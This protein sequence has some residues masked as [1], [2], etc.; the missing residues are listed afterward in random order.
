M[1]GGKLMVRDEWMEWQRKLNKWN[2]GDHARSGG[3]VQEKEE[4]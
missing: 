1:I 4:E 3:M 2:G